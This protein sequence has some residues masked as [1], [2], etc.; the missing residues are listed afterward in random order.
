[1][2]T[3][4]TPLRVTL[5]GGGTDLESYYRQDGGFIFAMAINRYIHITAQ[6]LASDRCVEINGT[7]RERTNRASDLKHDIARAAL[8]SHGITHSFEATILNDVAGRTG[9][10]SSGSFLVGFLHALHAIA[11]QQPTVAALA[12]EACRIEID[13]LGKHVGK[14]DQYMAA[15]GGLSSLDIAPDGRVQVQKLII[16]DDILSEFIS[17]THIYYTGRRR[18]S[19]AIL[20]AQ[21]KALFNGVGRSSVGSS[22][23]WIKDL[24]VQ[25]QEAWVHG[26]LKAWGRLLHEHWQTKRGLSADITWPALDELYEHVRGHFDVAGGKLIGAGGGGFLMLYCEGS[27]S[28]LEAYMTERQMPRTYYSIAR[29][30]SQVVHGPDL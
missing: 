1:M 27:G 26:D 5:G 21:H 17:R 12:E 28:K 8:E 16:P 22:L 11:G 14:Q 19:S 4:R 10:G 6:R 29:D 15:F 20:T 30:G 24:G 25:I 23:C 2:L 13:V 3:T 7:V 9:L 18:D